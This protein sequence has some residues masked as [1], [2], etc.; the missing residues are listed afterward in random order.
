[1]HTFEVHG[2]SRSVSVDHLKPAY[3]IHSDIEAAAPPATS[4]GTTTLSG[5]PVGLLDHFGV[6]RREPK[7][8]DNWQPTENMAIQVRNAREAV[9]FGTQHTLV[10]SKR[11]AAAIERKDVSKL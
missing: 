9:Y 1:M 3:I 11:P 4:S 5:T 6:C 2:V 7:P 10:A 8:H